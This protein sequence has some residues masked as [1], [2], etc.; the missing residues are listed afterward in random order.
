MLHNFRTVW[1]E[2]LLVISKKLIVIVDRGIVGNRCFAE[3]QHQS[4]YISEFDIKKYRKEFN[5]NLLSK[6]VE[7]WYLKSKLEICLKRINRRDRNG[8]SAYTLKYLK[9]L[10]KEHNKLLSPDRIIDRNT[11]HELTNNGLLP[12]IITK[13]LIMVN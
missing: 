11:D 10:E 3:I 12:E 7:T 8:E 2:K 1:Q 13:E 4:G 5:T 6:N 9:Q